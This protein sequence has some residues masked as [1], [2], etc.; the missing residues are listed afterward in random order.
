LY[1]KVMISR[2]DQGAAAE[3]RV[4]IA[5]F[6]DFDR[7]ISIQAVGEGSREDFR[8]VLDNN[9]SGA[10][11]GHGLEEFTKSFGAA[12]VEAPMAMTLSPL[13]CCGGA[14]LNGKMTS[15]VF[16]GATGRKRAGDNS[17]Y[18]ALWTTSISITAD[19][20][21]KSR[22]PSLGLVITSTAPS[23]KAEMAS[24]VRRWATSE[25]TTT[26]SGPSARI[27]RRKVRPSMRGIT[28]SVITTSGVPCVDD[29]TQ[30][31][32]ESS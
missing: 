32:R 3:D 9:D 8:H 28:R 6:F 5:G 15:A 23:S 16:R 14:G 20:W 17:A 19:S 24:S 13:G 22:T 26:G 1:Q 27:F 10:A 7:A 2:S 29:V 31:I 18:A 21:R 11:E 12:G 4:A 25:H 30:R